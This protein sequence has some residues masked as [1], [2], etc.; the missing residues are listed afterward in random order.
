MSVSKKSTKQLSNNE[1]DPSVASR[2]ENISVNNTAA[3]GAD[4]NN[5]NKKVILCSIY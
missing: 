1:M 3:A 2:K 4:G 5:T